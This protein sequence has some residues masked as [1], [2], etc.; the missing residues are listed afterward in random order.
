MTRGAKGDGLTDDT[1]AVQHVFDDPTCDHVH[2]PAGMYLSTNLFLSRSNVQLSLA[3]GAVLTGSNK[4]VSCNGDESEWHGVCALL[5]IGNHNTTATTGA[6]NITLW[7]EGEIEQGGDRSTGHYSALHFR[8]LVG[9]RVGGGLRV[10]CV[11]H[12]W[13]AQAHN[14]TDLHIAD[15]FIDGFTGRDGFDLIN[16]RDVLVENSRIEGSDDALVFKTETP[17]IAGPHSRN[18]TVRNCLLASRT[19]NAIQFGSHTFRYAQQYWLIQTKHTSI[20]LAI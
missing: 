9:V 3:N 7:G 16:V 10:H 5:T 6:L 19:C 4:T 12:A 20:L 8:D 2:F 14:I 17:A 15:L 18:V 13:C 11:Q 1:T